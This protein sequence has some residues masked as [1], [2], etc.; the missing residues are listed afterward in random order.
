MTKEN[1]LGDDKQTLTFHEVDCLHSETCKMEW[2]AGSFCRV[3]NTNKEGENRK[4]LIGQ[5]HR[6]KLVWDEKEEEI[7]IEPG[8]CLVFGD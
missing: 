8:V 4:Y 3:K 5:G 7:S 6:V 1:N 2:K